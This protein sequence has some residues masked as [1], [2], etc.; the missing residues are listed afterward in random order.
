MFQCSQS[1][2]L[3][4]F[5][6]LGH[7]IGVPTFKFVFKELF[8]SSIYIKIQWL[9]VICEV[10][11]HKDRQLFARMMSLTNCCIAWPLKMSSVSRAF[12]SFGILS[13]SCFFDKYG[14]TTF[15]KCSIADFSQLS[16][17]EYGLYWILL[18]GLFHLD[19]N[20][21]SFLHKLVALA[22]S[23]HLHSLWRYQLFASISLFQLLAQIYIHEPQELYCW[24]THRKG[25]SGHNLIRSS[26]I[27][28]FWPL[29]REFFFLSSKAFWRVPTRKT[30]SC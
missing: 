24:C 19:D 8:C 16:D 30:V 17:L 14:N 10:F 21:Q 3:F 7:L 1:K 2:H 4:L 28:Y 29:K 9:K 25:V 23:L 5:Y 27:L 22:K 12:W 26:G 20:D 6:L 11:R 15:S 18:E 13:C